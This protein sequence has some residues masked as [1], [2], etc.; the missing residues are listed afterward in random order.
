MALFI[1]ITG[2]PLL[3]ALHPCHFG[4]IKY[5][6][7]KGLQEWLFYVLVVSSNMPHTHTPINVT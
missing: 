5:L 4:I 1:L 7:H 3:S 2:A 6:E